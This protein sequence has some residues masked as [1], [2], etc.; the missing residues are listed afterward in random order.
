MNSTVNKT[1]SQ[2]ESTIVQNV[3]ALLNELQTV[4]S[5][6]KETGAPPIEQPG[7]ISSVQAAATPSLPTMTEE[8]KAKKVAADKKEEEDMAAK[9]W[10]RKD[11]TNTHSDVAGPRDNATT[12]MTDM[13][14]EI[15]EEN[16]NEVA[17]T[18]AKMLAR[19]S[20]K[21]SADPVIE[22]LGDLTKVI[23]SLKD[24][25]SE[26]DK[27]VTSILEGM[28][29][30]K[31][32]EIAQKSQTTQPAIPAAPIVDADNLKMAA[33]MATVL[34]DINSQESVKGQ[35]TLSQGEIVNKNLAQP[36][37]LQALLKYRAK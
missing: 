12:E 33:Y 2:E 13:L 5:A 14:P 21:K 11:Q 23:K 9:G 6:T 20:V 15:T 28:G 7:Q 35:T 4:Q 10:V 3:K 25:Q 18:I 34:K 1:L 8:E 37:V 19:K 31:Q 36:G 29:V 16:V 26:T 27:A 30:A 24:D 32:I 22:A 17:K